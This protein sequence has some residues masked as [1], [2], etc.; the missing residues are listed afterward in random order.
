MEHAHYEEEPQAR[1]NWYR[2]GIFER[3]GGLGRSNRACSNHYR[4]GGKDSEKA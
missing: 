3:P 2:P 4:G 1:G